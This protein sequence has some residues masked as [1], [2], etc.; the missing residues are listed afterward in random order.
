[1]SIDPKILARFDQ[2]LAEIFAPAHRQDYDP[3]FWW[4]F[5]S[6]GVDTQQPFQPAALHRL[7]QDLCDDLELAE[8]Q[9]QGCKVLDA[10][11]GFGIAALLFGVMGAQE[12]HGIDLNQTMIATF[13]KYLS[14]FP[15][16]D[17]VY[18]RLGAVEASGYPDR[19][20]DFVLSS[21]AI[22]HYYDVDG[23]IR[24]MARIVKPGGILFISDANNGANP[25][26][27][28]RTR[29]L[30]AR[31]ENGPPGQVFFSRVEVPY[32]QQ[33]QELIR[34]RFPALSEAEVQALGRGSFGFRQAEIF[35]ACETYLR[36]GEMPDST[37]KPGVTP[38][39][40]ENDNYQERLIY[41]R[42]LARQLAQAGFK[43][44]TYAYLGGAGG[45]RGVRLL[46]SLVVRLSPLSWPIGRALKIVAIRQ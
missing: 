36:S 24:E 34:Q 16:L 41:P 1:M 17:N 44:R 29:K 11:C 12:A 19:Y 20:F 38:V 5:R 14:F 35:R 26:L 8:F 45:N 22:S 28:W 39:D 37:F 46:N 23:F 3:H 27:A 2:I 18:P 33:R 32:L 21:E 43:S 42:P 9:P 4:Y 7:V 31:F 10:G 30:W 25:Y 6:C 40:P 15:E 13:K